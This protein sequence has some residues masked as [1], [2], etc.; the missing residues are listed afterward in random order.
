[1]SYRVNTIVIQGVQYDL[2][3]SIEDSCSS[4]STT[5]VLSARQGMLLQEQL[6]NTVS[7]ESYTSDQEELM[8]YIFSIDP[9]L[10]QFNT[11]YIV[12]KDVVFMLDMSALDDGTLD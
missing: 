4:A 9:S 5:S 7:V 2:T 10:I 8:R 1:M 11:S 3:P 12:G 6:N